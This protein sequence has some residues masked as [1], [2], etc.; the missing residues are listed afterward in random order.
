[1]RDAVMIE[2]QQTTF[3]YPDSEIRIGPID[4][5]CRRGEMIAVIGPNGSGKTT[6]LRLISGGLAARAGRI[7]VCGVDPA[8]GDRRALA[9][10]L[11]VVG[12]QGSLGFPYSA[13]EV[14]LMGRAPHVEGFHLESRRDIEVAQ[15]SLAATGVGHLASRA[16]DTLS[17]GERQRV[18]V[19]RALA[20]EPEVLL[21]DE[22]AAFLDIKQQTSLYDLMARL[23][24]EDGLTVVSVLHDL[25]LAS[26]YFERVALMKA[27]R[28]HGLGTPEEV[29]TYASIRE[30]FDTDVYVDIND[31]TGKLNVLPLPGPSRQ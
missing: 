28:L 17:S 31:L 14:V 12:Q 30:V 27:G 8:R 29:I 23:N 22:P 19:A 21:L 15:R 20:Q 11:A 6:L 13:F 7:E 2:L 25:N 5:V 16:F 1:M 3:H 4:L 9:R 10:K 24:R 18:T 26:L